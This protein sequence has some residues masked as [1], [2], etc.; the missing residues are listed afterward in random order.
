MSST[1]G[2][3]FQPF[4]RNNSCK[5]VP[6][7]DSNPEVSRHVITFSRKETQHRKGT[8]SQTTLLDSEAGRSFQFE[9][10]TSHNTGFSRSILI[11]QR[12][13]Q[14]TKNLRSRL[15]TGWRFGAYMAIFQASVV[16]L[17]NTVVLV[18]GI[19][20]TGGSTT[21]PVFQGDCNTIGHISL[22]I[23]LVINILSTLLLGAS[24]YIMQ[25]LCAPTRIEISQAH[26]RR[27]WLDIGIQSVRNLKNM[28]RR[29]RFLWIAI[30]ASSIPLH[31]FYNSSFFSTLSANEYTVYFAQGPDITNI[32]LNNDGGYD[33]VCD[34]SGCPGNVTQTQL[35]Q[36][37]ILS[38]L[39][40]IDTYAND[41]VSDR[42][43]VVAVFM[44]KNT[45]LL[46]PVGLSSP[47]SDSDPFHWICSGMI[48][49]GFTNGSEGTQCSF[50]WRNVN[51][52]NWRVP[53][54]GVVQDALQVNYCLSQPATSRCQLEFNLPLLAIVI[55]F[56]IIKII[57]IAIATWTIKDN[58]LV[59]IG[60]A[61]A[62]FLDNPD[63]NTRGV[64]L[65]PRSH[66]DENELQPFS[67]WC[68]D[69]HPK[70]IRWLN[71]ASGQHWRINI[72]L[73][74]GAIFII[75]ILLSYTA[76][77]VSSHGITG[78]AA[79]WQFG[80]G[81]PHSE[82]ILGRL[83]SPTQAY[84]ALFVAVLISNLPQLI[85]SMI[86]LVF[87]SLCTT[88]FLA[89]E[90]SSYAR[91]RK[92]LRVSSPNGK[93][94]STYFLQIPYR[95]SLP[96][97]AYSALL[98][99]LVSQSVFLVKVTYWENLDNNNSMR[100]PNKGILNC[101]YSPAGMILTIIAGASL[102]PTAFVVCFFAPYNSDMPLV[103]SCSAAI[104]AACHPP[105]DGAD[106]LKPV[107]WGAVVNLQGLGHGKLGT[108]G[109]ICFSSGDV[110]QPIPGHCYS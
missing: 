8:E 99:W 61:I 86:Y 74:T 109:H 54:N 58:P 83:G 47:G 9:S 38:P 20:R 44:V 1:G 12:W 15:A 34:P 108:V 29:K 36:W 60:D 2:L 63:P 13:K 65:A 87:N 96:L 80:V 11:R 104:A 89:F 85:L 98:H 56:N 101:G 90:W 23:H 49:N 48:V 106:P 4:H 35:S 26:K 92:P 69:Y 110:E 62:S 66:F 72:Y 68:I 5:S 82:T 103:R 19:L 7:G 25:S 3:S 75:I 43:S 14:I 59:T 33:W 76:S 16:L 18:W 31:L 32:T 107:M 57:C 21:G 24:N 97:L 91:C 67:P 94:R 39:E 81:K 51:S 37:E 73:F 79:L 95:F 41:F 100:D 78:I 6:D 84:S 52:K 30:A 88:L 27:Y 93:Q 46:T 50:N 64:C 102:I 77:N 55:I 53:P 10:D 17:I 40:C 71:T 22:G 105:D 45:T 42:S 28:S 70:K